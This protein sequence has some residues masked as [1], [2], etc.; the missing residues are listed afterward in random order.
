MTEIPTDR[1]I[2]WQLQYHKCNRPACGTCRNGPGHGPYWSFY[3]HEQGEP[4]K[5]G[6]GYKNGRLRV[7]YVGKVR[8]DLQEL[9]EAIEQPCS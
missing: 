2:T 5:D 4:R 9:T 3:Y 1:K 6:K 8:P 7:K